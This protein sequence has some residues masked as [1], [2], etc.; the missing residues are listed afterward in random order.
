MAATP[1]AT[2]K[3]ERSFQTFHNRFVTLMAH[4]RFSDWQSTDSILQMEIQ[5]RNRKTLQTTGRIPSEVWE[6]QILKRTARLRD[7]PGDYP[8]QS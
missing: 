4:A 3:I 6:E 5:R 8:V 7:Y 1:L 2:A